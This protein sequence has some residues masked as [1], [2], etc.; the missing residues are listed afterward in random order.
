M[1]TLILFVL[2][3]AVGFALGVCSIKERC[4]KALDIY[5]SHFVNTEN[6]LDSICEWNPTQFHSY[7]MK[8]DVYYEYE[9]TRDSINELNYKAN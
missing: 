5:E 1:K 8:T 4:S 2:A 7:V 3:F 6:L 9:C